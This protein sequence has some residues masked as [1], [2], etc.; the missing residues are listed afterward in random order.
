LERQAYNAVESTISLFWYLRISVYQN[1]ASEAILETE[2]APTEIVSLVSTK[3]FHACP[4]RLIHDFDFIPDA[5][6]IASREVSPQEIG[7]IDDF[8]NTSHLISYPMQS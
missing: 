5:I 2:S 8:P 6:G 4:A 3:H 1:S 7:T